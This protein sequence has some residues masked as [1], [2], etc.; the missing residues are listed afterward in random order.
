MQFNKA[1]SVK[2][3]T[4]LPSLFVRQRPFDISYTAYYASIIVTRIRN[5]NPT[6][7]G[8]FFSGDHRIIPRALKIPLVDIIDL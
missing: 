7:S 4:Q 8:E 5:K 2:E 1:I 6:Q 3:F